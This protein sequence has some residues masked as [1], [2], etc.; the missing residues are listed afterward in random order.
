MAESIDWESWRVHSLARGVL[1]SGQVGVKIMVSWV[2]T[3]IK[4]PWPGPALVH[5]ICMSLLS[6]LKFYFEHL[7]CYANL[8]H[9]LVLDLTMEIQ[10]HPQFIRHSKV[11]VSTKLTCTNQPWLKQWLWINPKAR[12]NRKIVHALELGSGLPKFISPCHSDG[13]I[14]DRDSTTY[15]FLVFPNLQFCLLQLPLTI[16][17]PLLF[18]VALMFLVF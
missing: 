3:W 11:H 18:L 10:L 1:I 13:T 5:L 8:V 17:L 2:N 4:K 14:V 15:Q 16:N 12:I 7:F 9:S 6:Q